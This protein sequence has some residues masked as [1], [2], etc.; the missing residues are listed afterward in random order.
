VQS[1]TDDTNETEEKQVEPNNVSLQPTKMNLDAAMKTVHVRL[2]HNE[3]V[4]NEVL[5]AYSI[6]RLKYSIWTI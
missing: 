3:N 6:S 5:A 4:T 1:R 2:L